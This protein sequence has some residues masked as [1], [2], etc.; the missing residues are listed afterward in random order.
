MHVKLTCN[1]LKY[2]A[3]KQLGLEATYRHDIDFLA[4]EHTM[5]II[6]GQCELEEG[7]R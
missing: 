7:S 5:E 3:L 6:D 2:L 4:T 1:E